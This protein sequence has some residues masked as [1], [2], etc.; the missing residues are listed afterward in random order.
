MQNADQIP[1]QYIDAVK[2]VIND[3]DTVKL[4]CLDC[5]ND[6]QISM[7]ANVL[8][9]TDDASELANSIHHIFKNQFGEEYPKRFK[10]NCIYIAERLMRLKHRRYQ[11]STS[12]IPEDKFDLAAVDRIKNTDKESIA[13]V[14]GQI[15][16]W[17]EDINWP[18]AQELVKILPQFD[19]LII[20]Y[21][22]DRLRNPHDLREYTVYYFI[23][24][25]LSEKQLH[26]LKSELERVAIYPTQFEQ[27][28]GYDKVAQEHLNRLPR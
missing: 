16:E 6:T 11:K 23:L 3:W 18:V 2:E 24:P 28:E 20:P 7:I 15:F 22:K 21:I 14:I 5:S 4:L 19:E 10:H 9:Q 17:V 13:P 26:L 27:E 25:L 1:K 12:L 8:N